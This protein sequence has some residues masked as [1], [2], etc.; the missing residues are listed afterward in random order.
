MNKEIRQVL[1][2]VRQGEISVEQA[3]LQTPEIQ[4]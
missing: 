4:R 1:E 3:M 2:G